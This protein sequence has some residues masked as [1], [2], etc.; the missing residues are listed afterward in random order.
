MPVSRLKPHW[1]S[2][3]AAC[4]VVAATSAEVA[5]PE[6]PRADLS[7]TWTSGPPKGLP[8]YA[9]PLLPKFLPE[10]RSQLERL[11]AARG[12]LE[13]ARLPYCVPPSFNPLSQTPGQ[14]DLEILDARS[15]L[16]VIDGQGLVRRLY[17][18]ERIPG[19]LPEESRS[20]SS[21]AHWEDGTLVVETTGLHRRAWLMTVP[22]WV[23]RN[24]R[25]TERF[26]LK[27]P[28]TLEVATTIRA[29]ELLAEPVV[30][31]T[32]YRRFDSSSGFGGLSLCD[33]DDRS[34][35]QTTGKERFDMTPPP[36][37][38]PPPD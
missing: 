35:D 9:A 18:S 36:D 22:M 38:P 1:V 5:R 16:V 13:E 4:W 25:V 19:S 7:G 33:E 21:I 2:L 31:T 23:G 37:L 10:P 30:A 6:S 12:A 11:I 20:G 3:L 32:Q 14:G 34:F 28:D 8:A 29:P 27:D 15:H 26:L 17:L 24:V